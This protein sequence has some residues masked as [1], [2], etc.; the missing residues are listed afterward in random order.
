MIRAIRFATQL[1]FKIDED[2]LQSIKRNHE[3]LKI[4]SMKELLRN[5]IK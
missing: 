1:N 4:I 5:S 2:S 3:R